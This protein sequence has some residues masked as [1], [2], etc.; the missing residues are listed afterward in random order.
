MVSIMTDLDDVLAVSVP[1]FFRWLSRELGTRITVEDILDDDFEQRYDLSKE[2]VLKDA[3][4]IFFR[5]EKQLELM[6]AYAGSLEGID[7]KV[8]TGREECVRDVT[9]HWLKK[10]FGF[11]GELYLTGWD[12]DEKA[13]L[14]LADT[15]DIY[16]DDNAAILG[17]IASRSDDIRLY[18]AARPWNR[19]KNVDETRI[20]RFDEF[21][22][23]LKS[24]GYLR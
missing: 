12:N 21:Q 9:Y 11:V 19:N 6:P 16:L 3:Q 13:R 18:L 5:D 22:D 4:K 15:P 10:N 14:T 20:E 7:S 17:E 24:A 23:V 1:A 8:V 2:W